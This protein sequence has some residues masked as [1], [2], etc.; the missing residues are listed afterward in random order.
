[1]SIRG[2]ILRNIRVH[3]QIK[4]AQL[5]VILFLL[6]FIAIRIHL[7]SDGDDFIYF[8]GSKEIL[9]HGFQAF[10][11]QMYGR[12]MIWSGRIS[13]D[14][15]TI[16]TIVHPYFSKVMIPCA[17]LLTAFSIN[18]M[19]SKEVTVNYIFFILIS[20]L[21]I[22]EN[23]N[24]EAVWWVMGSYNYLLPLSMATYVLSF[25]LSSNQGKIEFLTCVFAV[26][27]ASY[28]ELVGFYFLAI[29][30]LAITINKSC[31]TKRFFFLFFF[32]LVNYCILLKA[33]GNYIRYTTESWRFFPEYI[34]YSIFPKLFLGFD[35]VY[36][37]ISMNWNFP[38]IFLLCIF[39]FL[40][41]KY[42]KRSLAGYGSYMTIILYFIF[43][44][45]KGTVGNLQGLG[46]GRSFFSGDI[47][48][49]NNWYLISTYVSYFFVMML[50][51]SCI[52]L[53]I[54]IIDEFRRQV[55]V[56]GIFI[57]GIL[58]A[59]MVGFSPT[60][61]VSSHRTDYCFEI[62]LI[63]TCVFFV[64]YIRHLKIKSHCNSNI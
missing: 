61:Y 34:T 31:R 19:V 3:K 40:Y 11:E 38:F 13:I 24:N 39:L 63:I 7:K 64:S 44:I 45:I 16:L 41:P 5:F 53:M 1:M 59:M 21:L 55:M 18:R 22:P 54:S 58:D 48:I 4:V 23:I 2:I 29:A 17:L 47:F 8:H 20:L 36:I 14:A 57:V 30:L 6:I 49:D 52:I 28:S 46:L 43:M 33:P 42:G 35:R 26:L 60:I 32:F 10:L 15:I 62:C 9:S 51:V 25:I 37:V 12:Y 27:I 56:M 50:L